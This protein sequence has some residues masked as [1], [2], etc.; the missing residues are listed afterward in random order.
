MSLPIK[1]VDTM[2]RMTSE[3]LEKVTEDLR[4]A[5]RGHTGTSGGPGDFI[6]HLWA[7]EVRR[8]LKGVSE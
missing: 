6:V 4:E 2:L 8:V 3:D 7:S 1:E 5:N